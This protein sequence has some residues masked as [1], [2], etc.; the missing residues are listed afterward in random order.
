MK[1]LVTGASGLLGANVVEMLLAQGHEV[2]ILIRHSSKM[3]GLDGLSPTTFIGDLL[4]TASLFKAADGCKVIVH[5]AANSKQWKTSVEEHDKTNIKGTQ[6]IVNVAAK[7]GINRLVYVST[8]NTFLV[9]NYP[10]LNLDSPY[11]K[12]KKIAEEYVLKQEIIPAVV[13]CPSFMIGS[14]DS[15]PSSGQAILHYMNH[16]PVF[17]PKGGKSFVHVMDVAE[18]ILKC[19]EL[20]VCGRKFLLANDNRSYLSFFNLVREVTGEK[21]KLISIPPIISGIAGRLGSIYGS[22]TGTIPKLNKVNSEIINHLL[23]YDGE[24][25]YEELS[26][27]KRPLEIAI[28]DAVQWFKVNNYC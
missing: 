11:I 14:R 1:V 19:L 22:I 16:N 15:K 2:S 5:C 12:S 23:Y 24:A 18:A 26:I 21:R 20:E 25:A 13:V 17:V 27:S 6:N 28:Y 3:I 4:D 7:A 9:M 8:A 10:S